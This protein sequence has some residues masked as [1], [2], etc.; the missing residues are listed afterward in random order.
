MF[1]AGVQ[2]LAP[3]RYRCSTTLIVPRIN[4]TSMEPMMG[5]RANAISGP[6]PNGYIRTVY[7]PSTV[8]RW[9]GYMSERETMTMTADAAIRV[10]P[11]I[12]MKTMPGW[13]PNGY[14]CIF[15][16][17]WTA[18]RWMGYMSEIEAMIPTTHAAHSVR[19]IIRMKTMPGWSPN[20]Y[21]LVLQSA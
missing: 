3:K 20:G 5:I 12:R 7:S 4:A 8:C 16:S 18:G 10:R 2:R 15:Y 9:T 19:P 11:M 21:M 13:S 17:A 1:E 14:I 6:S